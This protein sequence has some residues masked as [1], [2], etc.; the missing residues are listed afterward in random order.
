MTVSL[1]KRY[2]FYL[3]EI[4][5]PGIIIGLLISFNPAAIWQQRKRCEFCQV[6]LQYSTFVINSMW[7]TLTTGFRSTASIPQ[8]HQSG[9][10]EGESENIFDD[11]Y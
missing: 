7:K 6:A 8:G 10:E 9:E 4:L 5:L 1:S 2:F 3:R 11:E